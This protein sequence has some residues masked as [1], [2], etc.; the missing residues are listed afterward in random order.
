METSSNALFVASLWKAPLSDLTNWTQEDLPNKQEGW[1]WYWRSYFFSYAGSLYFIGKRKG[2]ALFAIWRQERPGYWSEI[3]AFP[4]FSEG[5]QDFG[6]TVHNDNLVICGGNKSFIAPALEV[7]SLALNEPNAN[8]NQNWPRVT[9]D[10]YSPSVMTYGGRLHVT[11]SESHCNVYTLVNSEDRSTCHWSDG[12]IKNTPHYR[13]AVET[14]NNCL[15]AC[16]GYQ[17]PFLLGIGARSDVYMYCESYFNAGNKSNSQWLPLP[18][19][20]VARRRPYLLQSNHG[21]V[22]L[23]GFNGMFVRDIEVLGLPSNSH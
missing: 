3:N 22:C 18:S 5:W 20:R 23:S 17:K 1:R 2:N 13:S 7:I 14:V 12:N 19:L 11:G 16:A 15:V 10:L 4:H 21:L 9:S 8:W 6:V